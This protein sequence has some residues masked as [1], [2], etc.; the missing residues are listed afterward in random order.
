MGVLTDEYVIN[1]FKEF[2]AQTGYVNRLSHFEKHF[3]V[4]FELFPAFDPSLGFLNDPEQIGLLTD[5]YRKDRTIYAALKKEF[6]IEKK[7][8]VFDVRPVNSYRPVFNNYITDGFI[9]ADN[10]I[11]AMTAALEK[12]G[13][14]SEKPLAILMEE[15]DHSLKMVRD[16]LQKKKLRNFRIQFMTVFYEGYSDQVN[17]ISK[18]FRRKKKII[19]LYLYSQGLL[20]AEYRQKLKSIWLQQEIQEKVT[21]IDDFKILDW[22]DQVLMLKNMG[23]LDVLKDKI[24]HPVETVKRRKINRIICLIIGQQPY[25]TDSITDYINLIE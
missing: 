12:Q 24:Q 7:V 8:Y 18:T 22:R 21:E 23:I 4:I 11:N 1:L 10:K 15:C 25:M 9:S 19:E 5:V 16:Y 17:G 20:F 14:Y 6:R 2:T 13:H 3:H